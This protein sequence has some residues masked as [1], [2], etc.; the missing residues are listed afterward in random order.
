MAD[1][2]QRRMTVEEFLEWD[3]G[4]DARYEL[5]D[6][7]PVAMSPNVDPHG[8]MV[9]ELG[10]R[11]REALSD[12]PDC[13]VRTG[14]GVRSPRRRASYYI[15][16]LVVACGPIDRDGRELQNPILL[17]EILS[18]STER[19]DRRIKLTDYRRIGSGQEILLID[20]SQ[21]YAELH[22][23]LDGDRWLTFL[24]QD[25]DGTLEL[26]SVGLELPLSTLYPKD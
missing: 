11:I 5:I 19:L 21:P 9:I 26:K 3:D 12:R 1:T 25:D 22:R 23:R 18:P 17:V 8:V 16:D 14:L 15:P 20:P 13:R 2:A 7:Q 24:L 6:G 10:A 4:T